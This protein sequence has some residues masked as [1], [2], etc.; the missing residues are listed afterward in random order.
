MRFYILSRFYGL[1]LLSGD[2]RCGRFKAAIGIIF[3]VG[4]TATGGTAP[5]HVT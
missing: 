3:F 1:S 2:K 4:H 5:A